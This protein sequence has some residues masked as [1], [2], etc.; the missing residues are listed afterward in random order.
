MSRHSRAG[1]TLAEVI[2]AITVGAMI[3]TAAAVVFMTILRSS[4]VLVDR[5]E[6]LTNG[7]RAMETI[8]GLIARIEDRNTVDTFSGSPV[9]RRPYGLH[10]LADLDG[11]GYREWVWIWADWQE[12]G[13][14]TS[15][16]LGRLKAT[17]FRRFG[18]QGW[19]AARARFDSSF[20]TSVN[21]DTTFCVE[22]AHQLAPPPP[23]PNTLN[24]PDSFRVQLQAGGR[25]I[26]V[27]MRLAVDRDRNGR[28]WQWSAFPWSPESF[29]ELD[30][31]FYLT[32]SSR[33]IPVGAVN[34]PGT[35]SSFTCRN[36][37]LPYLDRT[38]GGRRHLAAMLLPR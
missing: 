28:I 25:Q 23:D 8:R 22:L 1:S 21:S 6:L 15:P 16:R 31:E 17:A 33:G 34:A 20:Y 9:N 3:L 30:S 24:E 12:V 26:L 38:S 18:G 13:T 37:A 10:F 5:G 11:D 19:R 14:P 35:T 2:V 27:G 32:D 29:M 4:R 7:E 36:T